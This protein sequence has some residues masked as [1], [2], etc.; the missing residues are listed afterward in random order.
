MMGCQL[1]EHLQSILK[2]VDASLDR[3]A[4]TTVLRKLIVRST[5]GASSMI[6]VGAGFGAKLKAL[7]AIRCLQ[8]MDMAHECESNVCTVVDDLVFHNEDLI[9]LRDLIAMMRKSSILVEHGDAIMQYQHQKS[10]FGG[11]ILFRDG[12]NPC[13]AWSRLCYQM[14]LPHTRFGKRNC[15]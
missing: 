12:S 14:L 6:G 10:A 3:V 1:E 7:G 8:F 4:L 5:D 2:H 9:G 13:C 15:M 11:E